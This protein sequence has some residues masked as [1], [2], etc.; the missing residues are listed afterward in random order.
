[1]KPNLTQK[2]AEDYIAAKLTE[3]ERFYGEGK[4]GELL[5]RVYDLLLR[6]A[7][8]PKLAK[9]L[10]KRQ[11][12]VPHRWWIN[13]SDTVDSPLDQ[14]ITILHFQLRVWPEFLISFRGPEGLSLRTEPRG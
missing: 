10:Q 11:D 5:S 14:I 4:G 9:A 3:F 6:I 7:Y 2:D 12:D 13:F 1:M 8:F